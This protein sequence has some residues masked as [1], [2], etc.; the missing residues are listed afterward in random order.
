MTKP[1]PKTDPRQVLDAIHVA[2]PAI[3][4]VT[5]PGAP[6]QA[7]RALLDV[8]VDVANAAI[9]SQQAGGSGHSKP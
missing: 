7:T 9:S 5:P 6:V 8:M 4:A 1:Y 2:D 3:D